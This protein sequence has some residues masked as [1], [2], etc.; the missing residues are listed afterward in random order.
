MQD[1]GER[2][3]RREVLTFLGGTV[4]TATGAIAYDSYTSPEQP[5]TSDDETLSL[6]TTPR[7]M[8]GTPDA[9]VK[10]MMWMDYQCPFCKRFE[11]N[12]LPTIKSNYINSSDVQAIWKPIDVFG[13]DSTIAARAAHSVWTLTNQ[14]QSVMNNWSQ[15]VYENQEERQSGWASRENIL[16][17]TRSVEGISADAL[18]QHLTQDNGYR[19]YISKDLQEGRNMGLEGTPHFYIY[20][21]ENISDGTQISGAQPYRRFESAIDNYL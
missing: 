11:A 6:A 20:N 13:S 3:S 17:Y 8:L 15:T 12:T 7:P 19:G 14:N 10:L 4:T 2:F 21:E 16:D 1:I 9:P 5:S 18:D